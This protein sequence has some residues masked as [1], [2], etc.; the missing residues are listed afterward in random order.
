MATKRLSKGS[1]RDKND[2]QKNALGGQHSGNK[3]F[4]KGSGGKAPKKGA[5]KQTQKSGY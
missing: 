3:A 1:P 5:T 2:G 4:S